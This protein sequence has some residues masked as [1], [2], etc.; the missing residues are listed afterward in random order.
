MQELPDRKNVAAPDDLSVVLG[1]A[2]MLSGAGN[3]DEASRLATDRGWLDVQ[4]PADGR[5]RP[6][7]SRAVATKRNPNSISCLVSPCSRASVAP[8][9][10]LEARWT[11]CQGKAEQADNRLSFNRIGVNWRRLAQ[12]GFS[13]L[14]RI[15][16]EI[17]LEHL[18]H[19]VP[20]RIARSPRPGRRQRQLVHI[21]RRQ[22]DVANTARRHARRPFRD[23]RD[24]KFGRHQIDDGLLFIGNLR[25]CGP[26]ARLR[27]TASW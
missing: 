26:Q 10:A 18:Q 3:V 9:I 25:R 5:R 12:T 17:R 20:D 6:A 15:A 1:F 27:Q 13:C 23:D 2:Q 21:G 24:A 11:R 4:W 16:R 14:P 22:P 8:A 19:I 7:R